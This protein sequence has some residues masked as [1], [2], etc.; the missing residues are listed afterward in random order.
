MQ[1]RGVVR[2]VLD[3]MDTQ[4]IGIPTLRAR[5]GPGWSKDYL[6]MR[7]GELL[8]VSPTRP[9]FGG[10]VPL[11]HTEIEDLAE[12]LRVPVAQLLGEQQLE[13]AAAS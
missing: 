3:E 10:R 8:P 12:A 2:R 11:T 6:E 7:L 1:S 13:L 5:L 4:G 9:R